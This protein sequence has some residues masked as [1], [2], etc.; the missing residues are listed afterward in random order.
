MC[1]N[2]TDWYDDNEDNFPDVLYN[3]TGPQVGTSRVA[4][5]GSWK[6]SIWSVTTTVR[7]KLDPLMSDN[8]LGFRCAMDVIP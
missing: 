5:G 4:R 2:G 7:Y 8:T 3:P 1:G 6:S